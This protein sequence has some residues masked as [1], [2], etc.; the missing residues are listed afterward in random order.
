MPSK[1]SATHVHRDINAI[2]GVTLKYSLSQ[3]SKC[4]QDVNKYDT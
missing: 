3:P 4:Y 1:S 2:I